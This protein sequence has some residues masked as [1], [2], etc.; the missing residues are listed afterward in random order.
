MT[1]TNEKRNEVVLKTKILK[2]ATS[3]LKNEFVGIDDV[4]DNVVNSIKPY[5]FF[6]E[7]LKRPLVINIWG[8]T[9]TG[10]NIIN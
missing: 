2:E 9:G 6:S 1:I 3:T 7:Y 8:L 4:I 5:Y 10:K